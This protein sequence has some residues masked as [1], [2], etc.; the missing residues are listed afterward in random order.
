MRYRGNAFGAPVAENG[1]VEPRTKGV[2]VHYAFPSWFRSIRWPTTPS[3]L[4][5]TPP[6]R[7]TAKT[8]ESNVQHHSKIQTGAAMETRPLVEPYQM[9]SL[10]YTGRTPPSFAKTE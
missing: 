2:A 1:I 5:S 10:Y 4:L 8:L 9:I 3:M 6:I 7:G